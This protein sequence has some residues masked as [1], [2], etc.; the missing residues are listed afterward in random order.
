MQKNIFYIGS[1]AL[2]MF[3]VGC[4]TNLKTKDMSAGSAD[5]KR[6]VAIGNS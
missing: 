1:L 2:M 5:F 6:F 4:K 3:A